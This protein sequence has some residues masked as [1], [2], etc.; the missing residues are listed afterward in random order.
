MQPN[1][2]R[3][4]FSHALISTLLLASPCLPPLHAGI[5]ESSGGNKEAAHPHPQRTGPPSW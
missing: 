3:T 5:L 4:T 1:S 2:W